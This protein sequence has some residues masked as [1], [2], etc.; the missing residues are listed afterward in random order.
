ML[1][2][3]SNLGRF[4]ADLD[5]AFLFD[6]DSDRSRNSKTGSI[7]TR[8]AK[9][10]LLTG[11]HISLYLPKFSYRNDYLL[12]VNSIQTMILGIT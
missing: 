7:C 12:A 5:L 11:L 9:S 3:V 10:S 8:N 4:D 6:S 2:V 1:S